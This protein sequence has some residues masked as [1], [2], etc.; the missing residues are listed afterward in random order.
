MFVLIFSKYRL[1]ISAMLWFEMNDGVAN[2]GNC[3]NSRFEST[4]LYVI[5]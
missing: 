4:K 5:Q 2:V 3:W 1:P